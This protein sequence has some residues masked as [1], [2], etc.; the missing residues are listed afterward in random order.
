MTNP[1]AAVD[2]E[3]V[4]GKL[5]G[6]LEAIAILREVGIRL[7]GDLK[8]PG[9]ECKQWLKAYGMT[10]REAADLCVVVILERRAAAASAS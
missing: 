1:N 6:H 2:L 7:H 5:A 10:D 9:H 4:E 8:T 3:A